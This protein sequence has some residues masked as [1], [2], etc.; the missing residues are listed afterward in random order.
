[1]KKIKAFFM[2]IWKGLVAFWKLLDG[3]KRT[4][5]VIYWT[6]LVPAVAIIWP[7]QAPPAIAKILALI[8]LA[9]SALGLGHAAVKQITSSGQSDQTN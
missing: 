8:G 2:A 4:I 6:L 1:M 7:D 5:S 9:F 3:R